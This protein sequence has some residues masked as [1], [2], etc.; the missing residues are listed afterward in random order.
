MDA[1]FKARLAERNDVYYAKYGFLYIVKASGKSAA[2]LLAVLEQRVKNERAAE[3]VNAADEQKK[4]T[5]LRLSR[6][7]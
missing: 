4:I 1:A 5:A 3:L 6:I 2:E 7:C